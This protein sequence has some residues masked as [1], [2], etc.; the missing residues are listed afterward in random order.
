MFSLSSF[1]NTDSMRF[2]IA[3]K[4]GAIAVHEHAVRPGK[5]AREG[6]TLRTVAAC[7]CAGDEIYFLSP[8]INHSYCVILGV[9]HVHIAV[10]RH[11]DPLRAVKRSVFGRTAIAGETFL[12]CPGDLMDCAFGEVEFQDR[13]ALAQSQPEIPRRIEIE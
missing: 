11:A 13:V 8:H 7:S 2:G 9:G 3:D 4:Y 5:L 6:I 1:D 12:P 10:R